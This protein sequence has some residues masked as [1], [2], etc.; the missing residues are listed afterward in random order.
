[1]GHQKNVD[2]LDGL[3][4]E[5][6]FVQ[7]G[8]TSFTLT[9]RITRYISSKYHVPIG[10]ASYTFE[11]H[12]HGRATLNGPFVYLFNFTS[13]SPLFISISGHCQRSRVKQRR[14]IESSKEN[15]PT[16]QLP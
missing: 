12:I 5:K 7:L 4:F 9:C 10:E 15:K 11:L 14:T 16:D 2:L 3:S 6:R 13:T 1:L 8:S